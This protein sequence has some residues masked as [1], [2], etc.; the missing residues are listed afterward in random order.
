MPMPQ[1]GSGAGGM[2]EVIAR[3]Q[4]REEALDRAAHLTM[5]GKGAKKKKRKRK[6]KA[7]AETDEGGAAG[8]E[9]RRR[10]GGRGEQR[11]R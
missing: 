6:K 7:A 11:E 8:K 4:M 9:G 3:I 1:G 10:S 2:A 5:K